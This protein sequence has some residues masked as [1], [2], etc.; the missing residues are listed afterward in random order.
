MNEWM[1]RGSGS[2]PSWR[3]LPPLVP[4]S[5]SIGSV[6]GDPW[7]FLPFCLPSSLFWTSLMPTQGLFGWWVR[8]PFFLVFSRVLPWVSGSSIFWWMGFSWDWARVLPLFCRYQRVFPWLLTWR[9]LSCNQLL[10]GECIRTYPIHSGYSFDRYPVHVGS[11]FPAFQLLL[12]NPTKTFQMLMHLLDVPYNCC[13]IVVASSRVRF[14]SC[15][16]DYF[17]SRINHR[18][19]QIYEALAG[20]A[21]FFRG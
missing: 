9:G 18:G 5:I 15:V 19:V 2:Y 12:W 6:D 7:I 16:F 11:V 3:E 21:L 8:T 10:L 13:S 4:I 17:P 20:S 1:I 14:W